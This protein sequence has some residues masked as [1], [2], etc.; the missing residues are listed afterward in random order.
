MTVSRKMASSL[1]T[2]TPTYFLGLPVDLLCVPGQL[3][4]VIATSGSVFT[5][6][7]IF[8]DPLTRHLYS[9]TMMIWIYYHFA[10]ALH[11]VWIDAV[12]VSYSLCRC[13][14]GINMATFIAFS[15]AEPIVSRWEHLGSIRTIWTVISTVPSKRN[16]RKLFWNTQLFHDYFTC[17]TLLHPYQGF[18]NRRILLYE[19]R[20]AVT[21]QSDQHGHSRFVSFRYP[22]FSI[23]A[24]IS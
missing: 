17:I 18:L 13:S 3:F 15:K 9:S 10:I 22:W 6:L 23:R 7:V 19:S 5:S 20:W 2:E 4:D 1:S 12:I 14:E 8:R 24:V 21:K 11:K 16:M